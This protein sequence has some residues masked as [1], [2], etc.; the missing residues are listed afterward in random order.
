MRQEREFGGYKGRGCYV[1]NAVK[2]ELGQGI[3]AFGWPCLRLTIP[4]EEGK[5]RDMEQLAMEIEIM[6]RQKGIICEKLPI[7]L[8]EEPERATNHWTYGE[9]YGCGAFVL[10]GGLC[11][12]CKGFC[13]GCGVERVKGRYCDECKEKGLDQRK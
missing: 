13:P 3:N 1:N 10:M 6:L 8:D 4:F 11:D 2:I 7:A 9:C 12:N 5:E